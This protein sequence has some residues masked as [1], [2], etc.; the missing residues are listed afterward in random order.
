MTITVKAF[1]YVGAL[2][3][4][5]SARP[6]L[7]QLEIG[8]WV[9]Q[10]TDK[11]PSMTL[12][13]E[14]CC[15]G[16]RRLIYHVPIGNTEALLIVETRLDGSDATV[17]MA[18]QASPQ[19]MAIRRDD[20]HHATSVLKFNGAVVG[21]GKSTLSPDGKTLTNLL[22]YTS[23]EGGIPPGKYTEIWIRQ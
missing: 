4:M 13:I 20:D 8:T 23:S 1:L 17:K 12:T 9:R 2:V 7:A 16:G 3:A 19:T 21:T 14:A 18:G 10:A 22:E 11:M 6:A 5:T 15:N